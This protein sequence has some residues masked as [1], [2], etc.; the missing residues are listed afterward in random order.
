MSNLKK[1]AIKEFQLAGW[2]DDEGN[3]SDKMQGAVCKDVLAMLE[4]ISAGRHSGS[5]ASY[6]VNLF[7]DLAKYKIITPL[8]GED[9]EW[10][11]VSDYGIREGTLLLHQNIRETSVFKETSISGEV[12]CYQVDGIVWDTPDRGSYTDGHSRVYIDSFPYTPTTVHKPE[13]ENPSYESK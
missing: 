3:Y 7:A 13:T 2:L 8:T 12:T 11:D 5:S 9:D 1:H 10:D 4:V 6:T